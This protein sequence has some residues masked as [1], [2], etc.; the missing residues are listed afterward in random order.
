VPCCVWVCVMVCVWVHVPECVFECVCVCV[1]VCM[2][3]I[4]CMW[5]MCYGVCVMHMP[6]C[7]CVGVCSGVCVEGRGPLYGIS[8]S[9]PLSHGSQG[10]NSGCHACI[11]GQ[12]LLI[13]TESSHW[14]T[15]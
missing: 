5:Y 8:S 12:Q 2:C 9:L 7:V 6:W 3:A 13:S 10:S 1:C 4:L 14:P 11:T 15:I